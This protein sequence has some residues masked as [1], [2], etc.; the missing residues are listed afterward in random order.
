MTDQ[1]DPFGSSGEPPVQRGDVRERVLAE[2]IFLGPSGI[3]AGWRAALY[4]AFFILIELVLQS[5]IALDPFASV[6]NLLNSPEVLLIRE[7]V[8]LA[9]A[10]GAAQIMALIEGRTLGAYGIPWRGAFSA[11]FWQG[12]VWESRS[13]PASSC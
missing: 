7:L 8:L 2:N 9:G 11:R 5:L 6:A 4:V 3:R 12:T 13:S 1:L 10:L